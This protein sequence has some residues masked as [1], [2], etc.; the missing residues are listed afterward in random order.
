MTTRVENVPPRRRP[1]P[2]AVGWSLLVAAVAA[3]F[4]QNFGEMWLRW[5]PAWRRAG[6]SLYDRLVEGESYYTHGPAIPLVSVLIVVLLIRYTRIVVR[7]RPV[8]GG[9]VLGASLL[10]HLT[11][12]LAR[13]NFASGFALIGVLTGLV[14]VLWG[15]GALR[16]LW[17]PLVLL[18][19]MVPLPEVSIA[20][21]NFRLKMFAADWGVWLAGVVGVPARQTGNRVLLA[22]GESL[23][24]ANVCNGLRT[25]ISLLAFGA[26]YVYVCRLRGLWR[27]GLFAMTVPVAI[28]SNTVR[29]AGLVL[30]AH[31]W[32]VKVVGDWYHD[33]SSLLTF[34]LA[35]AMM[36]ALEHLVLWGRKLAGRPAK[37]VPL[38]DGQLRGPEDANQWSRMAAA[39]R[40]RR[41]QVATAAMLLAVGGVLWLGRDMA[42]APGR[43]ALQRA[44]PAS[45]TVDGR[46]LDGTDLQLDPRSLT[47]LGQPYYLFRR[48]EAPDA[49]RIDFC[50][51]FSR[52]NRKGTHPPDLCLEGGG[53][54]IIAKADLAVTGATGRE[55]VPCRELL[56]QKGEKTTYYLYTYKSGGDYTRSFWGQQ[57]RIF[58]SGLLSRNASGALIRVSTPVTGDVADARRRA[59]ETMRL[60][61][62]H[63][64]RNLP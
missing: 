2:A 11:A 40:E 25:L 50:L 64:D 28:L 49:P 31:V 15:G 17:F 12:C 36:F 9:L 35:L 55:T 48:F 41:G 29:I 24:V 51:L 3:G 53:S 19:F 30:V 20:Q 32:G 46:R 34:L 10:L 8:A 1:W 6:L 38:F 63:L 42:S 7:P 60:A 16:R 27:A 22:G 18:A 56:V 44:L 47:I 57:L 54:E 14:L 21:M 39:V 45:V 5:F 61:I 4:A 59:V 62:P 13:V 37:V 23:V 43:A 52:D 26:L 58:L 33:T